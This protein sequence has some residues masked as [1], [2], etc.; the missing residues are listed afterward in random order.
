MVLGTFWG[1]YKDLI[2]VAAPSL[3][4]LVALLVAWAQARNGRLLDLHEKLTTGD[5]AAA[6]HRLATHLYERNVALAAHVDWPELQTFQGKEKCPTCQAT[7]DDAFA[8][9][10][11]F[12][13]LNRA[14]RSPVLGAFSGYVPYHATREMLGWHIVWWAIAF[15]KVSEEEAR[16]A[17]DLKA[18]AKRIDPNREIYAQAVHRFEPQPR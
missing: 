18:L 10:W 16:F 6:L 14:V 11:F 4:A 3:I 13:R 7:V 12:Q 5:I 1:T 9:L 2:A 8:G 17:K 15:E